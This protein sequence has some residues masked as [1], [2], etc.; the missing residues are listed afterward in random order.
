LEK[1]AT[2]C[3][4]LVIVASL[5]AV[6][7]TVRAD[8]QPVRFLGISKYYAGYSSACIFRV[9]DFVVSPEDI[10]TITFSAK[11]RYSS[12]ANYQLEL[13]SHIT[14]KYPDVRLVVG[15]IT[16]G[17][18]G[19]KGAELWEQM[20]MLV[21]TYGWEIASHTRHHSLPPRSIDDIIGAVMDIE[22][23]IT[24]YRVYTYI[25]PYGKTSSGEARLL[26]QHGVRIVV[27]STPMQLLLPRNWNRVH[28]TVKMS[29]KLPWGLFLH[30]MHRVENVIG[31]TMIIYTHATSYDWRSAE[32]L[33]KSFDKAIKAVKDNKTWITVPSE[34]YRYELERKM[35]R[36]EQI[37]AT[38]Y[39]VR[40][41]KQLD[42]DP[43]PITLT[44]KVKAGVEDV[45]CN[46][47]RLPRLESPGYRPVPGYT[48]R[49]DILLVNAYPDSIIT[50]ILKQ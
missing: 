44:F 6:S 28:I 50:I 43:V 1:I 49:G 48:Q 18:S 25:P 46:D 9:D 39:I 16:N 12:F 33:L 34:L 32:S 19:A 22:G 23:N 7:S 36:V 4:L 45:R 13:T 31:G 3:V 38:S 14:S 47:T 17:G 11:N 30:M 21:R 42:F 5:L 2:I 35:I 10:Y 15:L 40:A 8:D 41:T 24:G 26:S 20:N 29:D 27:L 37:N